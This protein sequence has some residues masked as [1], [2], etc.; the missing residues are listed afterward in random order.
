[1]KP[2]LLL[3]IAVVFALAALVVLAACPAPAV[4][5]PSPTPTVKPTPTPSPTPTPTPSPT[6]KP[7]PTPT[8]TPTP[9]PSPTPTPV[10][11]RHT[12]TGHEN[13]CLTCHAAAGGISV[14][15]ANHAGYTNALCVGCHQPITPAT[16]NFTGQKATHVF[17]GQEDCLNCHGAGKPFSNVP[18]DHA[19]RTNQTC[20]I[21]HP[22][23][24]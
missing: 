9:K 21:C 23:K 5:S 11:I 4:P 3:L 8:P 20:G 17:L 24:S 13:Q 19:G 1:M 22:Q 18:A 14:V 7:T 2:K 10:G 6:P 15:P 16:V 12:V